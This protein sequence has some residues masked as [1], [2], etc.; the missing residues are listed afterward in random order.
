MLQVRKK[1][2][3]A[4][5]SNK[6]PSYKLGPAQIMDFYRTTKNLAYIL[7]MP[8]FI[9]LLFIFPSGLNYVF[10]LLGIIIGIGIVLIFK[11]EDTKV[12]K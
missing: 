12:S 2:K 11:L 10:T 6:G 7:G 5:A 3:F 4:S 1:G 8:V 9:F